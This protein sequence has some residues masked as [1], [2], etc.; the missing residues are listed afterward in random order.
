MIYY[1]YIE[2]D[3]RVFCPIN[4]EYIFEN[5]SLVVGNMNNSTKKMINMKIPQIIFIMKYYCFTKF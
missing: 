3:I 1:I 2:Q 4:E 5:V